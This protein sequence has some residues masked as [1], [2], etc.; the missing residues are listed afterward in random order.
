MQ[1][2][3]GVALI[4]HLIQIIRHGMQSTIELI[5]IESTEK[6]DGTSPVDQRRRTVS[7]APW[8]W[9]DRIARSGSLT[10]EVEEEG[11]VRSTRIDREGN[12]VDRST[13]RSKWI[14]S[15]L[16]DRRSNCP[17]DDDCPEDDEE[18]DDRTRKIEPKIER[19]SCR[20]NAGTE[21][22]D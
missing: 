21:G 15:K 4:Q 18:I 5:A 22:F 10:E 16:V 12:Q 14:R 7:I 6:I 13:R 2:S 8:K 1:V 19:E 20:R 3:L 17:E 9:K 11:I